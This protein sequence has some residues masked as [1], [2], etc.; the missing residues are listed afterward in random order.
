MRND[1]VVQAMYLINRHCKGLT[2]LNDYLWE[3]RR[4]EVLYG[5]ERITDYPLFELDWFTMEHYGVS[6]H[7]KYNGTYG[8]D[9]PGF[10][11]EAV[12][13]ICEMLGE[14]VAHEETYHPFIFPDVEP[15][16]F[17]VEYVNADRNY[18]YDLK[19]KFIEYVIHDGRNEFEVKELAQSQVH[20]HTLMLV[21]ING[22]EFHYRIGMARNDLKKEDYHPHQNR[23]IEIYYSET[24]RN[25]VKLIQD[26]L[27]DRGVKVEIPERW[28]N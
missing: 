28:R 21:K 10:S 14:E 18:L 25:A 2:V 20:G 8:R 13:A 15:E 17:R 27:I 19:N 23:R 16:K 6:L 22:R 1:K 3:Y 5:D 12:D 7:A 26:F 11:E 9:V 24:I 4:Q